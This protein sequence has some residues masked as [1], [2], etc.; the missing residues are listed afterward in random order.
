MF[1]TLGR[2]EPHGGG[3]EQTSIQESPLD[4]ADAFDAA[5][6]ADRRTSTDNSEPS[7]AQNVCAPL[8]CPR[9]CDILL[10]MHFG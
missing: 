1:L 5:N 6:F 9:L 4:H 8:P 10:I 2:R 7:Y 3:R